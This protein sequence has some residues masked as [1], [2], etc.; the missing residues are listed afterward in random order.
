M[1]TLSATCL[2][3]RLAHQEG[4]L[5]LSQHEGRFG[6]YWAFEDEN[7]IIE[8]QNSYDEAIERLRAL[9]Q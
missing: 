4:N 7:G 2:A 9:A 8:V 6:K 1:L 5:S 3:I